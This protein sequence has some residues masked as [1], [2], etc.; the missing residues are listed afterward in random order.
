MSWLL[1]AKIRIVCAFRNVEKVRADP[2]TLYITQKYFT[3]SLAYT[4][5]TISLF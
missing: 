2:P 3:L 1:L 5:T 4:C